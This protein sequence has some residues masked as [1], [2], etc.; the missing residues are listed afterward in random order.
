SLDSDSMSHYDMI[1]KGRNQLTEILEKDLQHII[2]AL[3]SSSVITREKC[4]GIEQIEKNPKKKIKLLLIQIQNQ[5]E[6][7]CTQFLE[8]LEVLCPGLKQALQCSRNVRINI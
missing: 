8:C 7:S 4:E 5:G 2:N 3:I 6:E 1:Q